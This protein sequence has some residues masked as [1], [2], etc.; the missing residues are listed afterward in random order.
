MTFCPQMNFYFQEA[1]AHY[2]EKAVIDS[3]TG[4]MTLA[5]PTKI[6]NYEHLRRNAKLQKIEELVF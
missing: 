3:Q 2:G 4:R 6:S 5:M 1:A